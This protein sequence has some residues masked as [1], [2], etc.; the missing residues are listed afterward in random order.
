MPYIVEWTNIGGEKQY[1]KYTSSLRPFG[2]K[3]Y[4]TP[5]SNDA[6]RISRLKD[7]EKRARLIVYRMG[8]FCE[9]M[10]VK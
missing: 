4:L 9:V 7:A 3:L 2:G 10:K 8:G 5:D 1:E 6:K